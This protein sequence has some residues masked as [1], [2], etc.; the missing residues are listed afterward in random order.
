MG[1]AALFA[2]F[3]VQLSDRTSTAPQKEAAGMTQHRTLCVY[4][5][6]PH[7]RPR[8]WDTAMP[9]GGGRLGDAASTLCQASNLPVPVLPTCVLG[10][11]LRM[12]SAETEPMSV[13]LQTCSYVTLRVIGRQRRGRTHR[14]E[15]EGSRGSP[16][17]PCC[18]QRVEKFWSRT[19][20]QL[21]R[22]RNQEDSGSASR[23]HC[24]ERGLPLIIVPGNARNHQTMNEGLNT[25]SQHRDTDAE[26]PPPEL[27]EGKKFKRI[28]KGRA[29][30]STGSK[31]SHSPGFSSPVFCFRSSHCGAPRG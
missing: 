11:V 8:P 25:P 12:S 3:L 27:L 5:V 16:T 17:V 30:R 22:N 6:F 2:S 20:S 15:K 23:P 4:Y 18:R 31:E 21:S 9:T 10:A 29:S 13:G 24:T 1:A 7:G 28:V 26:P 19:S 14:Q